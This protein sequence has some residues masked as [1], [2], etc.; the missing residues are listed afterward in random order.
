MIT[1]IKKNKEIILYIVFGI[2]TT[3]INWIVYTIFIKAFGAGI[4]LSNTVAWLAAIAFAFLTNK[5][6]VFESKEWCLGKTIKEVISFLG[7]RLLS[8]L[9]EIALPIVLIYFGINQPFFSID[10]G[11]AKLITNL[12]V[13]ILN[14]ILSKLFVFK[15]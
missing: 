13:I 4:T 14:Y 15:K 10:G 5:L 2:G 8:G 9:V 1:F 3:L 7:S 11:I 6:F 12:V